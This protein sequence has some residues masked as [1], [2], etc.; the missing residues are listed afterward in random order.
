MD[1]QIRE[2]PSIASALNTKSEK[3]Q[4]NALIY[5][6]GDQADDILLSFGLS[7]ENRKKCNMVKEKLDGHFVIRRNTIYERAKFNQRKQLP[8]ES[9]DDFITALYGLVEHCEYSK[10]SE[11]MIRDR[12]VVG[13]ADGTL[14]EKLQL[15]S[16][17]T[18]ETA[19]AKTR[20]S[21][22]VK[23]QQPVVRGENSQVDRVHKK[24]NVPRGKVPTASPKER[25]LYDPYQMWEKPTTLKAKLPSQRSN[26]P[27]L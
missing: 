23:K 18:L 22:T 9:I 12:I 25:T 2:I 10:L 1:L 17:L 15:D 21:E 24:P 13:I 11:T 14:A 4:V 6:M 3:M 20:E 19:I 16:R 26:L 5:F 8:G 7:E 27:S